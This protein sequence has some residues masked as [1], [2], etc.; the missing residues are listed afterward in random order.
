MTDQWTIQKHKDGGYT[1][2]DD[3]NQ[4]AGKY[5]DGDSVTTH[6]AFALQ[7]NRRLESILLEFI[8]NHDA[9]RLIADTRSA[10]GMDPVSALNV[11]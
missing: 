5:T 9:A 1:I 3:N 11:E 2:L 7:R 8:T 4:I 10:L 6:L